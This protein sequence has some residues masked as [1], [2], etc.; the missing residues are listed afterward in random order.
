[1]SE[2]RRLFALS[3][4]G[5]LA[6]ASS[7]G[8]P[9]FAYR[10]D[11]ARDRYDRLAALLARR[12]G[13]RAA[14]AYAVK[15]N[16]GRPLVAAFAE[17]GA[18]FDCASIGELELLRGAGVPG[19][20]LLLAGPGKSEAELGLALSLGARIQADGLED[21]ERIDAILLSQSPGPASGREMPIP[22][23]LRVHPLSGVSES[24]PIIGGSGPSA[25]GVDE[26]ELPSFLREAGRFPR[27]RI[28][29]LQVFAASNERSARRLLDN[30]RIAFA[31]G[32]RMAREAGLEL[33]LV[34]L[35]GGLGLTY[36]EG[37]AELD[38]EAFCEGLGALLEAN[39]WFKGRALIEPGRWLAG[40]C[41]VYLARVLRAK[42][43]RGERFAVLEGG[44]NHLLRP[45][46][47]GQA[48]PARA[49]GVGT[50]DIAGAREV[51]QTLAGPLCT[52]LD[53]LGK[54]LLPLLEAGDLVMLGQA[55]AY[56]ATEAMSA[57]LSH[58]P[59]AE[60]WLEADP[61]L[62]KEAI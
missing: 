14:L 16:P 47:T 9:C 55:G 40:P 4:E 41:G 11:L 32:E 22:V 23:S 37:E 30:H 18:W 51:E 29:G 43:S 36:A 38:L 45:A 24:S 53:R 44:A 17:R 59:A 15:A 8:T 61:M 54:V 19:G 12:S 2:P 20:R 21:L 34:D 48:F 42:S 57:F 58:P 33:D 39:P 1:L 27:V 3:D 35:G 7:R 10:L 5:A 56:G 60:Y 31:I 25:F 62:Y 28:A 6:L 46:L 26:E 52:S 50:T 49:P 13:G